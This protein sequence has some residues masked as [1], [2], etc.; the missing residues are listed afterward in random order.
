MVVKDP[1]CDPK[2]II[3]TLEAID[4]PKNK[5]DYMTDRLEQCPIIPSSKKKR[6]MSGYNCHIK[7]Q[8]KKTGKSLAEVSKAK[9]W[10]QFE[11]K[12]KEMWGRHAKNG[13][14]SY[15]W[16]SSKDLF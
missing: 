10:R 11:P 16:E 14:P 9:T 2:F 5:I 8:M 4:T 6:G 1:S 3:Q 7:V 12:V 13:C 15:L